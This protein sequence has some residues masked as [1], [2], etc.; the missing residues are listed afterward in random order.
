MNAFTL[1]HRV[2]SGLRHDRRTMALVLVAPLLILGLLYLILTGAGST[3]TV[4]V[5]NAPQSFVKALENSDKVDIAVTNL[6]GDDWKEPAA[7]APAATN[8][9]LR[10]AVTEEGALAAVNVGSDPVSYTH[11][12]LPTILLV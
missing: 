4:A 11:L 10:A 3:C 5:G 12:T 6:K 1:A 9:Q 2:L 7:D 8:A